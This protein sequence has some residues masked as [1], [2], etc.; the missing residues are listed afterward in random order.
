M[1][2]DNIIKALEYCTGGGSCNKCPY[3]DNPRLSF[4]GCLSSKM[5]DALSL[6]KELTAENKQF[7]YEQKK[8]IDENERLHAS[9]TELTRK[10]ESLNEENERLTSNL[11]E[12]SAEN[13]ILSR[14]IGFDIGA[15]RA[16]TVR[17]MQE[18][19]SANYAV[20]TVHYVKDEAPTTTYQLTNWQLDQIAKEMLEGEQ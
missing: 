2:R 14:R 20:S 5:S 16:D 9:C 1:E 4:E 6:I 11:V 13:I 17:K 7:R 18:I 10:C 19:I 12:Q 8:L 3:D 15:I